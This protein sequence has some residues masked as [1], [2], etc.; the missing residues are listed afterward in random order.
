MSTDIHIIKSPGWED[1]LNRLAAQL[2]SIR[3]NIVHLSELVPGDSLQA[4]ATAFSLGQSKYVSYVDADDEIID[5]HFF[6][7]AEDFLD[8]NPHISAAYSRYVFIPPTGNPVETPPHI[9]YPELHL[10]TYGIPYVHQIIVSRRE[11]TEQIMHAALANPDFP[12]IKYAEM[13]VNASNMQWGPLAAINNI[14]YRWIIRPSS[15]SQ[16]HYPHQL[17]QANTYISNLVRQYLHK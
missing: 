8:K 4:R 13:C 2:S 7:Q 1:N 9:W 6:K 5:P 16:N 15:N 14:A 10:Q 3:T 12:I 11:N 17:F